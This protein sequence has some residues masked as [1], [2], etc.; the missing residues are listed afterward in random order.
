MAHELLNSLKKC[1]L[2]S[3][4]IIHV[5]KTKKISTKMMVYDFIIIV[6]QPGL[7]VKYEFIFYDIT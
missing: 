4:Q 6:S 3:L 2:K 7:A 5:D 1:T